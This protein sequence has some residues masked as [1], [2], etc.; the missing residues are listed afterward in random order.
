MEISGG[1]MKRFLV[2]FAIIITICTYWTASNSYKETVFK[3][4]QFQKSNIQ[5][6]V[7]NM[8]ITGEIIDYDRDKNTIILRVSTINGEP[9]EGKWLLKGYD[10]PVVEQSMLEDYYHIRCIV[11]KNQYQYTSNKNMTGFDYDK[12]LFAI[13][14]THQYKILTFEWI[15]SEGFCLNCYRQ[16]VRK[17]I[18]KA[19]DHLPS[20]TSRSFLKA[21]LLGDKAAFDDYDTFKSLGLAHLFAISGLHFGVLYVTLK[22]GLFITHATLKSI[23]ILCMMG[24]LLFTIGPTASAQRAFILIVYKE[25]CD[26]LERKADPFVGVAM[27]LVIILVFQPFLVLSTSLHLSFYA[28]FCVAIAYRSI[29]K[30]ALPYKPLEAIRFACMIQ[31]LLLPATLY[32]FQSANLFTFVSNAL[33]VPLIAIILPIAFIYLGITVLNI[34]LLSTLLIFIL[35][36]LIHISMVMSRWMPLKLSTYGPFLA[37]DYSVVLYIMTLFLS[38]KIFWYLK[39]I[40]KRFVLLQAVIL[41]MTLVIGSIPQTTLS[42]IDVGHGDLAILSSGNNHGIIDTGDGRLDVAGLLRS[43]GIYQLEFVVLSHAHQDHI[44]DIEALSAEM[45]IKALYVNQATAD[46][47]LELAPD[48]THQI[49]VVEETHQIKIGDDFILTLMPLLGAQSTHDPNEDALVVKLN[50]FSETGYFL[51]DISKSMIDTLAFESDITFIKSAHHGSGTS[52]STKLYGEHQ[53]DHVITSCHTRYK[54]PHKDFNA[55]LDRNQ[56]PHYTTY[57]YGEVKL[58][59]GKNTVKLETYLK[60]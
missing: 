53:I 16:S 23:L 41:T 3:S 59:F 18:E 52:V 20:T 39:I 5:Y 29:F 40:K 60:P 44:G 15:E 34:S 25:G 35:D 8:S 13:G 28:Y 50:V 42:F 58:T 17:W 27:A 14:V 10:L 57:N 21:L 7:L 51:G 24:F 45:F 12:Y 9:S 49:V 31:V 47:I 36:Q 1:C 26:L 46:K 2:F 38:F 55:L 43:K 32:Y 56:I 4:K 11:N 37:I 6:D 48:L 33:M 19:L 30:K 22:K 54:M